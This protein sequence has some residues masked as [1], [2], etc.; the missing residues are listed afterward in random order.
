MADSLYAKKATPQI[1]TGDWTTVNDAYDAT[2]PFNGAQNDLG[3]AWFVRDSS[4]RL[5]KLRYVRLS[6]TGTI[7]STTI[8]GVVYWKD[9]TFQVVTP[10]LSEAVTGKQNMVAGFLLN[11]SATNGNFVFIQ[12]GGFLS[13]AY[14]PVSTAVDDSMI[15]AA[16]AFTL[17][18]V[19]AGTAST[20]RPVA[21]ALTAV[22]STKSDMFV[23]VEPME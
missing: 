11:A 19:A 22:A 18:R 23:C 17:A 2:K 9:N 1:T 6:G 21:I 15:G 10:T 3:S 14:A 7:D 16:G 20:Y 8:P 12:V 13:Q 5:K 4:G